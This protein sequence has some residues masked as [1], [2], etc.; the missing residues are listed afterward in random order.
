MFI[1]KVKSFHRFF[2]RSIFPLFILSLAACTN[3]QKVVLKGLDVNTSQTAESTSVNMEAIVVLGN[4]KFPNIE[5]PILNPGHEQS[6]GQMALQHLA[7]GTN[8]IGIK[9]DYDLAMKQNNALGKSLPNHR[10]FP[11]AVV[12]SGAEVVGIPVMTQSRI[13]LSGDP[14]TDLMIG[15]AIVIPAFDQ[16]LST[17]S[18]PLNLLTNFSFSTEVQGFGGLF[19]GGPDGE[20]GVAVIAKKIVTPTQNESTIYRTLASVNVARSLISHTSSNPEVTSEI[21][22]LGKMTAFRLNRLLSLSETLRV[23]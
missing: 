19:S 11:T 4:L 16:V 17:V 14:K 10:E 12:P 9:I 18:T 1:S 2:I 15:V 13:Y 23:K 3:Q 8:R 6:L 22:K 5:V 21:E 20:N 7:D